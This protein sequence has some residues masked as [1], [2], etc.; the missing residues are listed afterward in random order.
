M[1]I[2]RKIVPIPI[3]ILTI[4]F[5]I[6]FTSA[7]CEEAKSQIQSQTA[8]EAV[9]KVSDKN[10]RISLDL[11]GIDIIELLRLLSLKTGL[12]IVPTKGVSGRV[13]VYLN[14]M[15]FNDA[16]DII[17]LSQDLAVERK[18]EVINVM[19]SGEYEKMYGKKFTDKR[20]VSIITLVYAKPS[21]VFAALGQLKS[22]IGKIIVDEATGT[23]FL[24]DIPEKLK[25]MEETAK[26]L[27]QPLNSAVF[28][29]KYAKPAD[30]KAHI[31]TAITPGLG[32]LYIDEKMGKVVVSDL[33]YKIDK[34]RKMIKAFDS[35]PLQVF[36]EAEILEVLLDDKFERGIDW[37]TIISGKAWQKWLKVGTIDLKG[38]FPSTLAIPSQTVRVGTMEQ[39]NYTSIIRFLQT[40]GTVNTLS[41]PRIAV[42]NNQEAKIM[43]GVRQAYVSQTLSQAQTTTVTSESI[44]FVDVGIKLNVIPSISSDGFIVMKIKPEVSSVETTLTTYLGSTIPI[45]KT[46]EAES[47]VK[48]KDGTMI[49]IAGLIKEESPDIIT[50][51]PYLSKLKGAGFLFGKRIVERK[52]TELIIFIT[53][54]IITGEGPVE[55]HELEELVPA[56]I[57]PRDLKKDIIDDKIRED[58]LSKKSR[59]NENDLSGSKTVYSQPP[60]A[61]GK[62]M[63]KSKGIKS[64]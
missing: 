50:G 63:G 33:P 41:R 20:K 52:R 53:P 36:I 43:V 21:V 49:M 34:I 23:I 61:D 13:N 19:T 8:P 62:I 58:I 18:G 60:E 37:D 35:A 5:V 2:D 44:Q 16:L 55:D 45:I 46:S 29:L 15:T 28:D 6:V 51:W 42:V 47:V 38:F 57:M 7:E 12:T 9:S 54:H 26:D 31:S 27:D 25:M 4:L 22:D 32:E 24:I 48:V 11:K 10:D 17:L 3:F 14:D 40:Y 59:K 30:I 39:T 56:D 1:Y 64:Y